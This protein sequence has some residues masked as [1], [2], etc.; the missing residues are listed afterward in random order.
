M[1]AV[2]AD[3]Q[4]RIRTAADLGVSLD[5]ATAAAPARDAPRTPGEW[6]EQQ[7][8]PNAIVVLLAGTALAVAARDA[9]SLT[10]AITIDLSIA[11]AMS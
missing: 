4:A 10:S 5:D 2:L 1:D 8:W 6:L 9:T 11:F 3:L 7:W